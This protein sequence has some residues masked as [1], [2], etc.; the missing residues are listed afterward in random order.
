MEVVRDGEQ[1]TTGQLFEEYLQESDELNGIK[2]Q[3][4]NCE[5]G[6]LMVKWHQAEGAAKD[7]ASKA[8]LASMNARGFGIPGEECGHGEKAVREAVGAWNSTN[9][10]RELSIIDSDSD[11]D[12]DAAKDEAS[13][14]VLVSMKARGFRIPGEECGEEEEVQEAVGA[15]NST[16]GP[17]GVVTRDRDWG[18]WWSH[19][20]RG[21]LTGLRV[22]R[23]SSTYRI[24]QVSAR[25][26]DQWTDYRHVGGGD[27]GGE[28]REVELG[29]QAVTAITGYSHDTYGY[30]LSL[31]ATIGPT[32]LWG[33]WGLHGPDGPDGC[34]L[35]PSPDI[36]GLTLAFL[37]GYEES[38]KFRLIFHWRT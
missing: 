18:G 23:N 4:E 14:V 33:P 9:G 27:W 12:S 10:H 29:D 16:N 21:A 36:Q 11:S 24:Q 28:V 2:H 25:Y 38:G 15:W 26:G 1:K 13:T 30:T 3:L 7:E 35:R 19:R 17:R 5:L 6:Q 32:K 22:K 20:G 37:S 31:G 8:V 34:T